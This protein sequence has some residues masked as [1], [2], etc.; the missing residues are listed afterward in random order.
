M[1]YNVCYCIIITSLLLIFAL[2][3]EQLSK[4]EEADLRTWPAHGVSNRLLPCHL[5][6]VLVIKG[7]A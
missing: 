3:T 6:F 7:N 4:F 5:R 2:L 1:L